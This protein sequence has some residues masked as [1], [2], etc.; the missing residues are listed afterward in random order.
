MLWVSF[1][2]YSSCVFP[3]V[4]G[5]T[6]GLERSFLSFQRPPFQEQRSGSV[7]LYDWFLLQL[8]QITPSYSFI[9]EPLRSILETSIFLV[10]AELFAESNSHGYFSTLLTCI[11]ALF[12]FFSIIP[13][14]YP[15]VNLSFF[16]FLFR[17]IASPCTFYQ[18][19]PSLHH[20]QP[21][22]IFL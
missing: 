11:A 10:S 4:A 7:L 15:S 1:W 17:V 8:S 13:K 9:N 19:S 5:W 21:D 22:P 20:S 3:A 2:V 16:H 14:V 12:P 18:Y 6:G